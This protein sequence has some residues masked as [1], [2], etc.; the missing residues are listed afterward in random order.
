[1]ARGWESKEVEAQIDS[2]LNRSH[3][4]GAQPAPEDV[5]RQRKRDSLL[6]SRTRVQHDLERNPVPRHRQILEESLAYLNAKLAELE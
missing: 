4:R 6:L 2:F 1:M 3:V 5:E